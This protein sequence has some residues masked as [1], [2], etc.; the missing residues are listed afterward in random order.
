MSLS[1]VI[2]GSYKRDFP[3]LRSSYK[4]FG[5]LGC[6]VLSPANINPVAESDGFVYME[7][8]EQGDPAEIEQHHLQSI[9]KA[10]F[11]WVHDPE[12]YVGTSATLEIGHAVSLG[13]PVYAAEEPREHVLRQFVRV[14]QSPKHAVD[15]YNLFDNVPPPALAAFQSYYKQVA[16]TRGYET[17]PATAMMLMVEE[18]GEL[19][20]AMRKA[21]GSIPRYG[22]RP[23][24]SNVSEEMADVQIYLTHIAN[25]MGVD[26]GNAVLEKEKTNWHRFFT[27]KNAPV[28]PISLTPGEIHG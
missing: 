23:I 12:G 11:L 20:K 25:L 6:Q 8:Q 7:G 28:G 10:N 16:V 27:T 2:S 4:E 21:D 18:F 5:E 19:A 3:R 13:I 9:N 15:L 22:N 1:V 24:T 17:S 14:V 26:L